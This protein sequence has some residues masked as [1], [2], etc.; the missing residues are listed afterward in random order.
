MQLIF[1]IISEKIY[2]YKWLIQ[3]SFP[4]YFS[5]AT[6]CLLFHFHW[7]DTIFFVHEI[8][9]TSGHNFTSAEVK[10]SRQTQ[11]STETLADGSRSKRSPHNPWRQPD[12]STRDSSRSI[13]NC[14]RDMGGR[15]ILT[16][17]MGSDLAGTR[18]SQHGSRGPLW[19]SHSTR[20][21]GTNVG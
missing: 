6:F 19:H 13:S 14:P 15:C 11:W 1:K 5:F 21:P 7:G 9:P 12:A 4:S 3:T 10:L 20:S 2:C 8:F 16:I 17:D 18:H